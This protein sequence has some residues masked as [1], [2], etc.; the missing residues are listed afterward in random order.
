MPVI[1]GTATFLAASEQH[2]AE[3]KAKIASAVTS[4]LS[5]LL[6]H[7]PELCLNLDRCLPLWLSRMHLD[8]TKKP[9][10]EIKLKDVCFL[11]IYDTRIFDERFSDLMTSRYGEHLRLYYTRIQNLN[12]LSKD[13]WP[14]GIPSHKFKDYINNTQLSILTGDILISEL[15]VRYKNNIVKQWKCEYF[16]CYTKQKQKGAL[17]LAYLA[18]TNMDHIYRYVESGFTEAE[19]SLDEV[20]KV[21]TPEEL[22]NH[23]CVVAARQ[24]R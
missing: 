11:S 14:N 18:D 9:N 21:L 17:A 16:F 5:E 2:K 13:Y 1:G 23:S 24:I 7:R 6:I 8:A 20:L 12:S 15:L 4:V 3:N 10:L 22:N 19:A